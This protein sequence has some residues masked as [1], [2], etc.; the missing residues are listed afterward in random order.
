MS[1]YRIVVIDQRGCRYVAAY[2]KTFDLASKFFE[3]VVYDRYW[4][5][6]TIK[7]VDA[8]IEPIEKF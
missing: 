1:N 8:T 2:Y 5:N 4:K 7:V 3:R 6:N